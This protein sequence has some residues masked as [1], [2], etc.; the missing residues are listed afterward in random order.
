MIGFEWTISKF[1]WY[2][3]FMFFT[4]F[5]F[6]LYGMMTVAVTPNLSVAGII[7]NFFYAMWNLFS[8]F[9]VPKTVSY[10]PRGLLWNPIWLSIILILIPISL[11]RIPLWWRW[12]YYICPVSWTLYGLVASQF[13]DMT[14]ELEEEVTL[15]QFVKSYFGF[16][17]DF[18]PYV[19]IIIFAFCLLFAFTF[20]C[21]IKAFNFQTK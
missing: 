19:A 8:G 18:V 3:F 13:G 16:R 21:S 9:V 2:Q 6:T 12:Y 14:D 5:Y 1:L 11:Q 4:L 10:T 17:S 15:Q 20:A 7:S